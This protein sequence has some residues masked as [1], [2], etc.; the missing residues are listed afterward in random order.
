MS[1]R[2]EVEGGIAGF[3]EAVSKEGEFNSPPGHVWVK[4]HGLNENFLLPL[5]SMMF[6]KVGVYGKGTVRN[7]K[8]GQLL[9]DFEV[10]DAPEELK[11]AETA[12]RVSTSPESSNLLSPQPPTKPPVLTVA[13]PAS[14]LAPQFSIRVNDQPDPELTET[15]REH[16]LIQPILARKTKSGIERVAGGRRHRSVRDAN[17]TS[18]PIILHEELS[19]ADAFELQ[20]IENAHRKDLTDYEWGR[21]LKHALENFRDRYPNQESLAKRLGKSSAWISKHIDVPEMVEELSEKGVSRGK[22]EQLTARQVAE[23]KQVKPEKRKE[24][25]EDSEEMPTSTEI[26]E[27]AE[28]SS[29][30][31]P[32]AVTGRPREPA[33]PTGQFFHCK[34]CGAAL[35]VIH[36]SKTRHLLKS[37]REFD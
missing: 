28:R 13:N 30:R 26:E 18:M 23:L 12:E 36:K 6:V 29:K 10:Y 21:A 24:I 11:A 7:T 3:I 2:S 32:P 16:G 4:F 1:S 34:E 9:C 17:L 8:L 37:V 22:L 27:K 5:A 25:L 31:A 20:L 35:T 19:D 14:V 33:K 15:V